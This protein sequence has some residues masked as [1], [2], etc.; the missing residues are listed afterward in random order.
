MNARRMPD[1]FNQQSRE[2]L[3]KLSKQAAR[4][5]QTV[6]SRRLGAVVERGRPSLDASA[7]MTSAGPRASCRALTPRRRYGGRLARAFRCTM[8]SH[9]DRSAA[10]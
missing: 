5:G 10:F 9:R 7:S 1:A 2:F 4:A 6:R 3:S 8:A